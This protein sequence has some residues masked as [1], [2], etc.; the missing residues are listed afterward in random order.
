MSLLLLL[1]GILQNRPVKPEGEHDKVRVRCSEES[2]KRFGVEAV[3][4]GGDI[5]PP[6][7]ILDGAVSFPELPRGTTVSPGVLI[8]EILFAPDGAVADT[9][10]VREF[11][12]NPPF[13]AF[14]QAIHTTLRKW[15]YE[16]VIVEG[17]RMP[18]CMTVT[19][20]VNWG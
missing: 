15:K 13:P 3:R 12:L 10:A 18:F 20:S 5:E 17:E 8:G 9:W 14:N 7:R 2:K 19:V 11:Q 4:I 16:P 1:G 6:D